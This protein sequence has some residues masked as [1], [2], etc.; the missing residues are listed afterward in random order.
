VV[1]VLLV[2]AAGD[3][4]G[5]DP[6]EAQVDVVA[7]NIGTTDSPCMAMPRLPRIIEARRLALPSSDISVPSIFS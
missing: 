5:E 6:A 2:A 4:I 1:V 3:V 7:P